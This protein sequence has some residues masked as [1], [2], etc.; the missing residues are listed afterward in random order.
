[1][2]GHRH[3]YASVSDADHGL[4]PGPLYIRFYSRMEK[5]KNFFAAPFALV[6][7][8]VTDHVSDVA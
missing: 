8:F 3:F 6:C 2:E 7:R 5:Q 4:N 1:M